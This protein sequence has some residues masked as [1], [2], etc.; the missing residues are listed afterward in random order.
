MA[1][2]STISTAAHMGRKSLGQGFIFCEPIGDCFALSGSTGSLQGNLIFQSA[3]GLCRDP[4]PLPIQKRGVLNQTP[5]LLWNFLTRTPRN[6][7]LTEN[8]HLSTCMPCALHPPWFW[9]PVI[10]SAAPTPSSVK[11]EGASHLV[12][13]A[14]RT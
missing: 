8:L 7:G 1:L 9:T 11:A 6:L 2:V 4:T 5:T 13:S 14:N 12:T 3:S 10:Q